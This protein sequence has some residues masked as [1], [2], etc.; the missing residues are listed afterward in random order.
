ML[1]HDCPAPVLGRVSMDLTTID[2]SQVPM[3]SIGDDVVVLDSD[4]ISACSVYKLAEW[5]GTIPYEIVSRIG[6]RVRRVAVEPIDGQEL[7]AIS[8]EIMNDE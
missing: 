6:P 4:P 5:A 1:I 2:L 8:E 3:A 7:T